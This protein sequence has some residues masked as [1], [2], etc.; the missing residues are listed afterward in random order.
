MAGTLRANLEPMA[1]LQRLGERGDP[2]ETN[3]PSG[4]PTTSAREGRQQQAAG[5]AAR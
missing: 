5:R 3:R 2:T 1:L 4:A